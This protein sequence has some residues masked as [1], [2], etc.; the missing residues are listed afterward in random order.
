MRYSIFAKYKNVIVFLLIG[1]AL[2]LNRFVLHGSFNLVYNKAFYDHTNNFDFLN[3]M[4]KMV[5]P[6]AT[7]ATHNNLASRF[8]HQKVWLLRESYDSNSPDYVLID[9]R[10]EQSPNN[11]VGSESLDLI[12]KKILRDQNYKIIYNTKEQYVFKRI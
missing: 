10:Q 12:L 3:K 5:P 8:T 4:I 1:N 7:V 11:Y 2:F 9:N 6:N